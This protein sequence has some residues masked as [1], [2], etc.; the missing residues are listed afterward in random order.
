MRRLYFYIVPDA[1]GAAP[2]L[3]KEFLAYVLSRNGQRIVVED[4]FVPLPKH[5]IEQAR[6]QLDGLGSV[7]T[8][9]LPA[10]Q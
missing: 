3:A 6:R 10:P 4:G 8:G 2:A 7:S 5:L 9:S 1:N